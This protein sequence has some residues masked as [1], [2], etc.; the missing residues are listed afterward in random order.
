MRNQQ[1]AN[2]A[3]AERIEILCHDCFYLWLSIL[4]LYVPKYDRIWA[5]SFHFTVS[6]IR[7]I[8]Y[9]LRIVVYMWSNTLTKITRPE[10]T[11]GLTL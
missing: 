1:V 11:L 3:G 7:F 4:E 2:G 9:V 10:Q 6:I 5:I 8:I